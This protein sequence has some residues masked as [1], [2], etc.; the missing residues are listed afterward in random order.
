LS[1]TLGGLLAIHAASSILKK[2]VSPP[3]DHAD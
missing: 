1:L 2:S 3:V